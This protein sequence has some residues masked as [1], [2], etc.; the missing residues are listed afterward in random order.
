MSE[1][2]LQSSHVIIS[3]DLAQKIFADAYTAYVSY[4]NDLGVILVS[5]NTNTWFRK[6]HETKE[7]MLKNKDLEGTKSIAIREILIDH[8][9]DTADRPL[10]HELN[11]DKH[12][13]KI[14]LSET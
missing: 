2:K 9:I 10:H 3:A 7:Y 4:K 5:A 13:F 11:E 1:I 6:L 8:D 12:Y 14:N